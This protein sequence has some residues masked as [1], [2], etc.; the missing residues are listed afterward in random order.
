MYGR[1]WVFT[2]D[3]ALVCAGCWPGSSGL[4]AQ[5]PKLQV[6]VAS[7]RPSGPVPPHT[8]QAPA[9]LITGGPGTN[10]PTF[11]RYARVPFLRLVK[12]V[13]R[14]VHPVEAGGERDQSNG[15][16]GFPGVW[17]EAIGEALRLDFVEDPASGGR[18]AARI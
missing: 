7:V 17:R 4:L 14:A 1:F 16:G 3:L 10:D 15:V 8:A 13:G 5:E 2:E 9:G 11:L 6:D 12:A 18:A